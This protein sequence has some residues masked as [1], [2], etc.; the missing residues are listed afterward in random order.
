LSQI[1]C[2]V[3]EGGLHVNL[4]SEAFALTLFD[5]LED[6]NFNRGGRTWFTGRMV[7][8]AKRLGRGSWDK[9]NQFLLKCLMMRQGGGERF[10]AWE[11]ELRRELEMAPLSSHE[12]APAFRWEEP[13]RLLNAAHDC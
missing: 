11:G 3:V 6:P 1:E 2:K 8:V 13:G 5:G 10:M 12:L 9:V 4:S 7:N